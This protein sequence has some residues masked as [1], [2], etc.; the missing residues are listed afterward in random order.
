[1]TRTI[2]DATNASAAKVRFRAMVSS[3]SGRSL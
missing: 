1:M 2:A 3:S